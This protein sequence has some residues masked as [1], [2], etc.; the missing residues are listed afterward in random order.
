MMS[1]KRERV[2]ILNLIMSYNEIYKDFYFEIHFTT[3]RFI[4]S[5]FA[6]L[7]NNKNISK[8]TFCIEY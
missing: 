7:R 5:N 6:L 1:K 3:L 8:Y 4:A 2:L